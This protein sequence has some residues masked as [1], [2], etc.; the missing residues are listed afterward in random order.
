MVGACV[1]DTIENTGRWVGWL[2][3]VIVGE[4]VCNEGCVV[5]ALVGDTEGAGDR[6]VGRVK[7]GRLVG[8]LATGWSVGLAVLV[9]VGNGV[10]GSIVGQSVGEEV[11]VAVGLIDG[12]KVGYDVVGIAV[13]IVE[14]AEVGI[15]VPTIPIDVMTRETSC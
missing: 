3:T 13:G 8:V 1:G 7:T 10:V 5:G 2:S 6:G 14:G 15:S 11:G 9:I 12:S 4:A